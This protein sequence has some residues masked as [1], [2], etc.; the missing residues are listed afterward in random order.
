MRTDSELR[1]DVERELE[2]EPRVDGRRIGVAVLDGI[3]T[4]TGEV[5]TYAERWFAERA[6]ERIQGVRGIV[7]DLVVKSPVERSDLDIAR[8]AVEALRAN[9]MVPDERIKVR[10]AKGRVTLEGQVDWDYQRRAAE[11]V[12]RNLLGVRGVSN[13]IEIRPRVEPREVKRR[14]EETFERA[15]IIDADNIT[16]EVAGSEVTL[17]G[18]VRT[19][20]ERHAAEKAAWAAPGVT[21]VHNEILVDPA[22][23]TV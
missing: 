1:R 12:V 4:L 8:E 21:A 16:V 22:L 18:R 5:D 20:L 23:V 9:V 13:L 14:I 7:N 17:R 2:W 3:V 15:A 11:R 6:V 19:W 10:V